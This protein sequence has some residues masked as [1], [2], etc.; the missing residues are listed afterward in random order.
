MGD[1]LY[2]YE[3]VSG[4]TFAIDQKEQ[5]ANLTGL[6]TTLTNSLQVDPKTGEAT[7]PII[8]A[9][10]ESGKGVN[11]G[12]LMTRILANSG[13][14]DWDKIVTDESEANGGDVEE[15]MNNT[16]QQFQGMMMALQGQGGVNQVPPE[17]GQPP[18]S[19]PNLQ[20]PDP[21]AVIPQEINEQQGY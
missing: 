8:M 20:Q 2:D 12:E 5:Q 3:V 10:E 16:A 7:S 17:E 19:D 9:L 14:Q 6:W 4:S 21:A 1:T 15:I 13:I 11:L 18:M